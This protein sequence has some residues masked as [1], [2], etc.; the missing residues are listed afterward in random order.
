MMYSYETRIICRE[1]PDSLIAASVRLDI[2][3]KKM[4][5]CVCV[6]MW[7]NINKLKIIV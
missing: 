1:Q 7:N 6:K 3:F 5:R 2:A 4:C